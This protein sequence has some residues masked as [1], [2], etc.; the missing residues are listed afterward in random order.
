M[1][2]EIKVSIIVPIYNV[3]SYV[4]RAVDSI[5]SQSIKEIEVILIN[6][7]STDKSGEIIKKY[8]N[9][10]RV[11]IINKK[12][13]GQGK[14]RNIGIDI[15]RGLYIGFVDADDWID[16]RFYEIMIDKAEKEEALMTIAGRN[17]IDGNNELKM[18][19]DQLEVTGEFKS[20]KDKEKYINNNFFYPYGAI[21]CNKLY[22]SK[23]IKEKNIRFKDVSEVG[24]EDTLF[25]YQFMKN[26][27]KYATVSGVF[28]NSFQRSNSTMRT[29][30]AGYM[31]RTN[32]LIKS[33]Y[34]IEGEINSN[35]L[36]IF[37]YFYD[38]NI[39]ILSNFKFEN[40]YKEI[41][42]EFECIDNNYLRSSV[43]KILFTRIGKNT[44]LGRGFKL[45]G[46][47][48]MKLKML[49]IYFKWYKILTVLELRWGGLRI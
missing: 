29:Y 32:K 4:E 40:I 41:K 17:V 44:L 15:S 47:L 28:Y 45:K 16:E 13:E 11:I 8:E 33:L 21:V 14:A 42:E 26:I 27:N 22:L 5:L 7:G 36:S 49:C 18:T 10:H 12:N 9:D 39:E 43:K 48:F 25:N 31:E 37:I 2:R 46:I 19:V 34:E 23:I 38:R 24:S 35:V 30:R 1:N 3:E 20:N 6:D